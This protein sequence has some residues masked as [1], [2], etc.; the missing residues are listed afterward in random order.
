MF[1]VQFR[2]LAALSLIPIVNS[3][4]VASRLR[5]PG[6]L[7]LLRE[8]V[9]LKTAVEAW[10]EVAKP[11]NPIALTDFSLERVEQSDFPNTE[12]RD[13]FQIDNNATPSMVSHLLNKY[14]TRSGSLFSALAAGFTIIQPLISVMR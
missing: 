7:E 2:I 8:A 4:L 5:D 9:V 11:E 1:F 14:L 6:R 10:V 3:S 13:F 12:V